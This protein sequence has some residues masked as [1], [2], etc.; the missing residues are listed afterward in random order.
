SGLGSHPSGCRSPRPESVTEPTHTF[1]KRCTS[2][3]IGNKRRV[4]ARALRPY[5][6]ATI[7]HPIF[8][9]PSHRIKALGGAI[10][11]PGTASRPD[12]HPY[13][14]AHLHCL[15][16]RQLQGPQRLQ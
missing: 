5:L 6:P 1:P 4:T 12:P 14:V 10:L 13:D 16:A 9:C 3:R 11:L 2:E 8:K 15:D 7:H